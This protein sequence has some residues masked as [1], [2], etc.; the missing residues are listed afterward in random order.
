MDVDSREGEVSASVREWCQTSRNAAERYL[1]DVDSAYQAAHLGTH[2]PLGLHRVLDGTFTQMTEDNALNIFSN[3]APASAPPTQ[4]SARLRYEAER[5][6]QCMAHGWYTTSQLEQQKRTS[7]QQQLAVEGTLPRGGSRGD[8]TSLLPLSATTLV[9]YMMVP[10]SSELA[11]WL[12]MSEAACVIRTAF[13]DTLS[14]LIART[15]RGVPSS[16]SPTIVGGVGTGSNRYVWPTLVVHPLALD[17]LTDWY[18]GQRPG[19]AV[20]PSAHETAMA[21]YNRC[22]ELVQTPAVAASP[23]SSAWGS[24]AGLASV[25]PATMSS[26]IALIM[27][28]D[29]GQWTREQATSEFL[30]LAASP[31]PRH[32]L[33]LAN[34]GGGGGRHN[35][36]GTNGVVGSLRTSSSNSTQAKKGGGRGIGEHGGLVRRSG[37]YAYGGADHQTHYDMTGFVHRAYIVSM[38]CTFPESRHGANVAPATIAVSRALHRSDIVLEDDALPVATTTTSTLDAGNVPKAQSTMQQLLPTAGGSVARTSAYPAAP[39]RPSLSVPT[40]SVTGEPPQQPRHSADALPSRVDEDV[41]TE[42]DEVRVSF[43]PL[44]YS[45]SPQQPSGQ[46]KATDEPL[47]NRLVSHPL[48]PNDHIST[49]HCVYTVIG[50]GAASVRQKWVAVCWCDERGEYVEH[51]V[52]A[53]DNDVGCRSSI[54]AGYNSADGA[55]I[56]PAAAARVWRGCMRYQA[57]VGGQLRIVLGEWQGMGRAQACAWREYATAWRL[58][59]EGQQQPTVHLCLVNIGVNPPGGL[60]LSRSTAMSGDDYEGNGAVESEFGARLQ[61]S[62]VLHGHQARLRFPPAGRAMQ[63]ASID[64]FFAG[65]QPA[66]SPIATGYLIAAQKPLLHRACLPNAAPVSAV[67][68]PCFCVQLLDVCNDSDDVGDASKSKLELQATR[69]ILKQYFQLAWLRHAERDFQVSL[70]VAANVAKQ[71]VHGGGS[72]WP[73]HFLPLHIGII[74]DIRSALEILI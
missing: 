36:I 12:A 14:S 40:M 27:K 61:C 22:P 66:S 71:S 20:V 19:P 4:W 11:L 67:A 51:A 28:S 37:Y 52:F 60:S 8:A 41:S 5:L 59:H 46:G 62:L 72:S 65:C 35:H 39:L 25:V 49:L 74:E 26:R 30:G 54:A 45:P 32:L 1:G 57:L 33:A 31:E 17:C 43:K 44:G 47:Y 13:A 48:R 16:L 42:L 50:R 21:I 24:A 70:A 2:R 6:G 64:E 7:G 73:V 69:A 55:E 29:R 38:P 53:D 63:D 10:R 9:L 68:V 56:S 34:S 58:L 23:S 15:S 3:H 18:H